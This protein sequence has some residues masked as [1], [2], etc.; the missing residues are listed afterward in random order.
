MS[1]LMHAVGICSALWFCLTIISL[2]QTMN[3]FAV[4]YRGAEVIVS[5]AAFIGPIGLI[6]YG[7]WFFLG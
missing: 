5:P 6:V 2:Y 7:C 4:K 1:W 3:S